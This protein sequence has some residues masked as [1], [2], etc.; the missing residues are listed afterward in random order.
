MDF[1]KLSK[2]ERYDAL[3]EIADL[4][5]NQG[6]TQ[7]EIA[8]QFE[9]NRFKVAKLI[10]D[11]RNEQIVE[12]K[13]N[14]SN[15]RNAAF[16]QSLT[17]C[18]PLQKA[19]VVNT[20]YKSYAEGLGLLGQAGA[21]YLDKLLS[22]NDTLGITWGKSIQ[23]VVRNL[24]Q[25]TSKPITSVQLCGHIPLTA[26][27]SESRALVRS[28]AAS[29]LGTAFYLNTPLYIN[30]AEARAQLLREPDLSETLHAAKQ[31]QVVL[32]GIG[33][34][35]SLPLTNPRFS[36]YLEAADTAHVEIAGSIFGLVL[37]KSG[38]PAE[39]SLNRKLMSVPLEDILAAKHRI[40][41]VCGRHKAEIT[42]L[43]IR[44]GYI[45]ELITDSGTAAA[46]LN[47]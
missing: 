23:T 45:N 18:F 11:A 8:R 19:I 27:D 29:Y 41:V 5:Y 9:T 16:E 46:L 36:P 40:A 24:P 28:I 31:M 12:I 22:A 3:A 10:Q 38:K 20:Q 26:A 15:E 21:N 43:A 14:Y 17:S 42:A 47:I 13:I 25:Q 1:E 44:G 2:P 30:H 39:I 35:S 4:Y 34:K 33:G 37:D 6:L 32:T 7:A